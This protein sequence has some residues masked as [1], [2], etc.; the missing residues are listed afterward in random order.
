LIVWCRWYNSGDIKQPKRKERRIK[1]E[2]RR[3]EKR[4]KSVDKNK[5]AVTRIYG[6][7]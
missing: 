1:R 7:Y 4:E 5:R 2:E 3:E 6:T